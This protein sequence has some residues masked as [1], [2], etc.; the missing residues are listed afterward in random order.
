MGCKKRLATSLK[1]L[2]MQL[3]VSQFSAAG[4]QAP[5]PPAMPRG[6]VGN[7][8]TSADYPPLA[9]VDR[10]GG[11]VAIELA[12]GVDGRVAKCTVR[13]STAPQ[14]L[15]EKTCYLVMRR[16]RF[17]APLNEQG[18]PISG[19]F[20]TAINWK[21]AITNI[22]VDTIPSL[23]K[24]AESGDIGW[25]TALGRIYETGE[26]APIDLDAAE[27]WYGKAAAAGDHYAM[28]NL[29]A[30]F[31]QNIRS[32]EKRKLARPMFERAAAAGNRDSID[33]LNKEK[34]AAAER[35]A[36][37]A[38]EKRH[39]EWLKTPAGVR[40]TQKLEAEAAASR[41]QEE[42]RLENC[43]SNGGYYKTQNPTAKAIIERKCR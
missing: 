39:A 29:A 14:I 17:N 24:L 35:A 10:S 13:K 38:E 22:S 2:L 33:W 40:H 32:A 37:Q 41:K 8:V 11:A 34:A 43:L 20:S 1:L 21:P 36:R 15:E 19:Y 27:R 18:I 28:N 31:A 6:N 26:F 9:I 25:M 4:A 7:W 12:I 23:Q 16:A 42:Q 5:S 3:V 30:L